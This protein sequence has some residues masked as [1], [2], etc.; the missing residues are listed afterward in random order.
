L[1]IFSIFPNFSAAC[2]FSGLQCE[3]FYIFCFSASQAKKNWASK[4]VGNA[5]LHNTFAG[6]FVAPFGELGCRIV[7]CWMA[8]KAEK[9]GG[10]TE[11]KLWAASSG[12]RLRGSLC[13]ATPGT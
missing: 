4:Y 6:S 13:L 3:L 7:G 1:P 5:R 10:S 2:H 11:P 9:T 8:E 12:S